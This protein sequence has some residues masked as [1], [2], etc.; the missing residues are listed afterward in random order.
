MLT[1][2]P[3]AIDHSQRRLVT[4]TRST[5]KTP[6]NRLPFHHQAAHRRPLL[7]DRRCFPPATLNYHLK[8]KAS[9][10]SDSTFSRSHSFI[11]IP[12]CNTN[13]NYG[14]SQWTHPSN[15]YLNR[16]GSNAFNLCIRLNGRCCTISTPI[17]LFIK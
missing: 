9:S 12:I 3:A 6:R 17:N 5:R 15:M 10:K 2:Q 11:K 13:S 4:W 8:W 7:P 14:A 16:C 1:A